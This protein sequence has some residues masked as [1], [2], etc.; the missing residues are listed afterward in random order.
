MHTGFLRRNILHYK[1]H[2]FKYLDD[3]CLVLIFRRSTVNSIFSPED[4]IFKFR[5]ANSSAISL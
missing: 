1:I 2:E 3:D 5:H 4:G